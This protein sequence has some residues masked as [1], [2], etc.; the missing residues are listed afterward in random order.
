MAKFVINDELLSHLERLDLLIKNNLAGV[1]NRK[2]VGC[3]AVNKVMMKY[4]E[5]MI[6]DCVEHP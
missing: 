5:I 6:V 1:T 2:Q 4:N 3:Y